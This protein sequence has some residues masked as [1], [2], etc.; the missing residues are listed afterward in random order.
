MRKAGFYP[1]ATRTQAFFAWFYFKRGWS[2]ILGLSLIA[3]A[4]V[5]S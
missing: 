3:V 4:A 1:R 5:W 2:L